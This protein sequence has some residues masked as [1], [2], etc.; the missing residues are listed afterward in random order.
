[1]LVQLGAHLVKSLQS[2]FQKLKINDLRGMKKGRRRELLF[3][4]V[5]TLTQGFNE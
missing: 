1:M 3:T 5:R 4:Y 2:H